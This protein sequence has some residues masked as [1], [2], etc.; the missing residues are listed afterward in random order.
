MLPYAV[1]V[2]DVNR[3]GHDDVVIANA[4]SST[5]SVLLGS[6]DG[7]FRPKIDTGTGRG[8]VALVIGDFD[9]DGVLDVA[10]ASSGAGSVS[11]LRGNGDGG[12]EPKDEITGFG[13]LQ[14]MGAGDWDG[15]G[16]L[17][18]AVTQEN[19]NTVRI[20]MGHGDGSFSSGDLYGAGEGP[21]QGL[22]TD[23]NRDGRPDIVVANYYGASVSPLLN[24]AADPPTSIALALLDVETEPGRV[25]LR[26]Y[27][28][29]SPEGFVAER[30]CCGAP[31]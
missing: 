16:A 6:G 20:L 12:F 4:W 31:S 25:R 18:L 29:G 28:S 15:D 1:S 17:D 19:A 13:L 7:T 24:I 3:D 11:V 21:E 26:W 30:S 10:T 27:G 22:V 14:W 8:P 23:L 9:G 5:V 2:A